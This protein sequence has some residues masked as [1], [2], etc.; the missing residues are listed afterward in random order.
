MSQLES[1][2]SLLLTLK[3]WVHDPFMGNEQP[4]FRGQKETPG[5][6]TTDKLLFCVFCLWLIVFCWG[7]GGWGMT[8]LLGGEANHPVPSLFRSVLSGSSI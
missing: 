2:W 3:R 8:R 1:S 7:V 5:S 4:F 6:W